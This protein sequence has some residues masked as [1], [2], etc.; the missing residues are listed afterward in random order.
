MIEPY[1]SLR[2][3]RSSTLTVSSASDALK[4][5][6][7]GAGNV[8]VVEDSASTDAT[9]FV[10]DTNGNGLFDVTEIKNPN[11]WGITLDDIDLGLVLILGVIVLIRTFL[12]FSLEVEI[13]GRWPWARLAAPREEKPEQL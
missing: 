8:L 2:L 10:I 12:S 6:Q 9:P 7:T 13:E 1:Q 4:I 11:A 3:S 5:T